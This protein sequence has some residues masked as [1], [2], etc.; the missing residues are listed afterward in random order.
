MKKCLVSY[1]TPEFE[2]K[3]NELVLSARKFG[4]NETFSYT[5]EWLKTTDFYLNNKEIL[6]QP[7][8][9]GYWVWKPYIILE[10]M[11]QL[12]F[13]DLLIYCDSGAEIVSDIT[14]LID[15]CTQQEGILLFN[16]IN[17]NKLY[18]KKD[19][20]VFMGCDSYKYWNHPQFMAGYQ[21]YIKNERS[22]GFL[23]EYLK[24]IQISHLVDDTPSEKPNDKKFVEHRH[25]QSILTN[26]A[27]THQIKGYRNPS[28]GGN[29]LK[30]EELRVK[31][32]QLNHPYSENPD[33]NSDYPQIFFNKR[34]A[35]KFK[36][37]L[38]KLKSK[39]NW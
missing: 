32:E 29:H 16:A 21:V 15:L 22:I 26:L 33:L 4:I 30:K 8:G 1:A 11:K 27:I 17:K 18:T 2:K 3:Q 34:N 35:G 23:N 39:L 37:F 25:D 36:L 28:Q 5:T 24:Y 7:R 14:P 31:S 12:D 38:I 6:D 20:F 9:A 10:A 13:G 19:C